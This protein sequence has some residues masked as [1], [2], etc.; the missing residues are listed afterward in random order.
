MPVEWHLDRLDLDRD[1]VAG[2]ATLLD[3]EETARALRF[4]QALHRR[5]FVVRR[6][7]LRQWLAER[8][9]VA[10]AAVPI[11]A[12][13]HGKP[14]VPGWDRHFSTSHSHETMLIACAEAPVGC[15]IERI[16]PG[17]AWQGVAQRLFAAE[18]W[19]A[20]AALTEADGRTAFFRCWARK[21]AFVKALGH[22]LHHPLDAFVVTCGPRAALLRG[23]DG[24]SVRR[25]TSPI[26][27]PRSW[28]IGPARST[29][30]R[31]C[32]AT[33]MQRQKDVRNTPKNKVYSAL[34]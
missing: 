22:G 7:R 26:M 8:L 21:E 20:L 28:C 1:A 14:Y 31:G 5:R 3:A 19:Q 29:C 11:A 15:D 13:V 33:A 30:A 17:F 25:L 9:G 12:D 23:G 4:H 18:E 27:P 6:A 16:D 2:L 34:P 32:R 10:P 24:W